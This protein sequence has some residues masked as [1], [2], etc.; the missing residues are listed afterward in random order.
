MTNNDYNAQVANRKTTVGRLRYLSHTASITS[1]EAKSML[2][3]A[4]NATEE[5]IKNVELLVELLDGR[6]Q[7]GPWEADAV[8]A[9]KSALA[10]IKHFVKED[11]Q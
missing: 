5:L 6:D 3:S 7:L 10:D 9:T 1:P 4:A 8:S 11:T 2:N